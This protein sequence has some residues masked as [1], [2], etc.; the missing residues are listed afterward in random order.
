MPDP[1]STQPTAAQWQ[2]IESALATLRDG[3]MNLK[4]SLLD[5]ASLTDLEARQQAQHE[6]EILLHRLRG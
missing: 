2:E 1:H 5:L 3:L 6:T 4:M